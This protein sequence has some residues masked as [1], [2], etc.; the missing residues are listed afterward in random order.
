MCLNTWTFLSFPGYTSLQIGRRWQMH[1]KLTPVSNIANRPQCHRRGRRW[2]R[3]GRAAAVH[4]WNTDQPNAIELCPWCALFT[5]RCGHEHTAERFRHQLQFKFQA[6]P[7][8]SVQRVKMWPA[9]AGGRVEGGKGD[10]D[11]SF[12]SNRRS[13]EGVK[14]FLGMCRR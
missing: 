10:R 9:R 7:T 11:L 4:H 13:T 2:T 6:W 3:S 14:L 12:Q 5:L 8:P 1:R